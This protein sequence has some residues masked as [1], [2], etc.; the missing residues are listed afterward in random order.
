SMFTTLIEYFHSLFRDHLLS[1]LIWLPILGAVSV[2]AVKGD[3]YPNRARW[4]ALMT[5]LLS[6]GLCIPLYLGFN[7]VLCNMQ[8]QVIVLWITAF[9]VNYA[10]G[11]DGI[12]LP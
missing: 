1:L 2:V 10:L 12:S 4:V 6:I 5:S 7:L 11:V 8:F 3:A 9:N